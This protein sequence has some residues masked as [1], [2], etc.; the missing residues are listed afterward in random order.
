MKLSD[1]II[2]LRNQKG[3]SQEELA[4]F[5]DVSRQS[6]SK[7]ETGVTTPEID[8]LMQLCDIFGISLDVLLRDEL[9]VGG[10][11]KVTECGN[12]MTSENKVY[13]FQGV[14]IKESISDEN[15]LDYLDINKVE[16]WK[17][18]DSTKY[19]TAIFFT[20]NYP[21]FPTAVSK[22]L[23][24]NWFVDFKAGNTK[25]IVFKDKVLKYQIGN[26]GEKSVVLNECRKMGIPDSQLNW[27]E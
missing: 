15:I 23:I 2:T 26:Q 7:W 22:A 5:L 10:V 6:I 25:F 1:K 14:L 8:K 16:I 17:T 12:I 27:S 19:W 11:K 21:D 18:N 20:S 4:E 3:Y 24:D 9:S 13:I